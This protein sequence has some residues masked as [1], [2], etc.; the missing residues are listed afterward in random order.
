VRP[1]REHD[2]TWARVHRD[3]LDALDEWTDGEHALL[4]DLGYDGGNNH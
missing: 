3:L 2:T 1:G 4:A